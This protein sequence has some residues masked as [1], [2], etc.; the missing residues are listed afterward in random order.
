MEKDNHDFETVNADE[1]IEDEDDEDDDEED[2]D[3]LR[4]T[5]PLS[6]IDVDIKIVRQK[7]SIAEAGLEIVRVSFFKQ[8]FK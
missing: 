1:L 2:P 6:A 4:H 3:Y 7:M 8:Y 5:T